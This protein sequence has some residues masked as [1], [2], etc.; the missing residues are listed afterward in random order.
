HR[1]LD[2]TDRARSLQAA[3]RVEASRG[4]TGI[5]WSPLSRRSR[6]TDYRAIAPLRAIPRRGDTVDQDR[7]EVLQFYIIRYRVIGA[8]ELER[9]A[10]QEEHRAPGIAGDLEGDQIKQ[11]VGV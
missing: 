8:N 11:S 1:S 6:G 3:T 2:P 10:F 5:A 7:Q 4:S 9:L